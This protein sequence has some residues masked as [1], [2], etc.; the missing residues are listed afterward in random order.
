MTWGLGEQRTTDTGFDF[1]EPAYGTRSLSDVM[2]AIA[3]ALGVGGLPETRL[4]LPEASAYV[5]MMVD[6]MGHRLLAE[7]PREAPYLHGLL[8]EAA[9]AGVPSTTA[10]S[11]TS[12]GTGLAPGTHGL[13]GFTSRIPG[14]TDLLNA[15]FWNKKVDP[16]EWQPHPTAFELLERVGVHTT[17]VSKPE[18]VDSGLTL[19]GQ[20]G[21]AYAGVDGLTARIDA[22]LAAV[23]RR[24][25]VTYV[26]ESELDHVGHRHGVDSPVWRAQLQAV[27]ED[28]QELREALPADV[29]LLVTADHGMVDVIDGSRIDVDTVDG[30]R[31][32]VL[33]LGGEA[34]LRHVYCQRGAVG[35]VAA[36]WRE[37][38]ADRA[39]VLTREEAIEQGWFGA[40]TDTVRPRLGEIVVAAHD[41]VGLFSSVSFGYE[42]TLIGLHGSLTAREMLVP[43]VLCPA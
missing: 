43:L 38:L 36:T 15:L 12:L 34:R 4:R 14:T 7:H 13:V 5:V 16:L 21:A 10:T 27:D 32:G 30:L 17:V 37:Q 1:V 35:D 11:L 6:G 40:V 3:G 33:L 2:P 19:S 25:S 9:T 8:G 23:G 22:T 42:T 18:F 31:D 39:T 28:V 29:A 24:P 20:R 26:Y 41:D